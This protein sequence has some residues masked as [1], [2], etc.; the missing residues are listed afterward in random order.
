MAGR[1]APR[2]TRGG[3]GPIPSSPVATSDQISVSSRDD[4][5]SLFGALLD[6]DLTVADELH[7]DSDS[8]YISRLIP[9]DAQAD[10]ALRHDNCRYTL[11][12][13]VGR[14]P[15]YPDGLSFDYNSVTGAVTRQFQ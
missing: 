9:A 3:Q 11:R 4:C 1:W 2:R 8:D 10:G 14:F 12:S 6:T 13:S 7:Q 5:E 15:A